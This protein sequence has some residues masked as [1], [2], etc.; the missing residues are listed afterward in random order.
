METDPIIDL[1]IVREKLEPGILAGQSKMF[2]GNLELLNLHEK[3]ALVLFWSVMGC[4]YASLLLG[5]A[6]IS[7][8]S[9]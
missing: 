6:V 5:C 3:V 4:G 2:H 9:R 1:G 7:G 8:E